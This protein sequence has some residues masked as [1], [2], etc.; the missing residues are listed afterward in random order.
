MSQHSTMLH[1]L[2]TVIMS[3]AVTQAEAHTSIMH[4]FIEPLSYDAQFAARHGHESIH[5]PSSAAPSSIVVLPILG[6]VTFVTL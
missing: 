1:T 2:A 3:G 6:R 5:F 4:S